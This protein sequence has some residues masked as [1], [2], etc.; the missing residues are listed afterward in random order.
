[1]CVCVYVCVGRVCVWIECE[2]GLWRDAVS[3]VKW[4]SVT[5]MHALFR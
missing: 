1:M 2:L 5:V 3:N 4:E